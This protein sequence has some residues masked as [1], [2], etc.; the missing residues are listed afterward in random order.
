MSPPRTRR[1]KK[2]ASPPHQSSFV[3]ETDSLSPSSRDL[4]PP[5]RHGRKETSAAQ[6]S[7]A[8][9]EPETAHSSG[10]GSQN[11]EQIIFRDR[12][13]RQV[14]EEE[15]LKLQNKGKR[16][17][18]PPPKQVLEWGSGITQKKDKEAALQEE[19]RLV[20]EPVARYDLDEEFD[21]ELKRVE[22]WGDPLTQA[23]AKAE[24]S[25]QATEV[26]HRPKCRFA[27]VPNRYGIEPGYRWD[28]AIRGTGFE[29]K[30]L[31]EKNARKHLEEEEYKWS[32]QDW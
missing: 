13:G 9:D 12:E 19:A 6:P 14:D 25:Q 24:A 17:R 15:W 7:S 20:T 23:E 10:E 22:R 1:R 21:N 8:V 4:S 18:K 31:K 11:R 28:G 5:R 30:L 3:P 27:A 29:E 16:S 32:V 26:S 2:N